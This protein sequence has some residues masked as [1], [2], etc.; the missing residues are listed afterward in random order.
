MLLQVS[1][2]GLAQTWSNWNT[3]AN[4]RS[5]RRLDISRNSFPAATSC[6]GLLGNLTALQQL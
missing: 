1:G 6:S 3:T 5:L 2:M 4:I